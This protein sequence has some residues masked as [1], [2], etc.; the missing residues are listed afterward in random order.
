MASSRS[1]TEPGETLTLNIQYFGADGVEANADSTPTILITDAEGNVV[2]NTT[3]TDVTRVDVGLYEY[4]FETPSNA[5]VGLWTDTWVAAIEGEAITTEFRFLIAETDTLSSS[6]VAR[7]GDDVDFDFSDLEIEGINTMLKILK[8]RLRSDGKKPMRDEFGAF[9]Y[10][11]YGEKVT[12][13]CN[14]FSD[15]IL[16]AFL[17]SA[18]SEFN[19][20]P[21]FTVYTFADQIMQTTFLHHIVEGAMI[22]AMAS[23]A[24]V[25]RGRDFTISDGGLSYQPP[26]LGEFLNSQF[27]TWLTS[28]RE[29]LK[30]VKNS[31]RPGPS[32]FGTYTNLSSGAPAWTRL[33]HMR[34]RKIV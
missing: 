32:S 12:V 33:R 9:V 21:F 6:G 19:G 7:I 34:S 29:R 18:L 13:D 5:D 10:D 4:E 26:T 31:I 22:M 1:R 2:V 16:V 28:Y 30:F 17:C 3:S 14:V 27:T 24:L 8:A 20:V 11:A 15:D 23:Q 25:E